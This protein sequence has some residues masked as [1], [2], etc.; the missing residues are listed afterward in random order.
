M[1]REVKKAMVALFVW[2][3]ELNQAIEKA[4]YFEDKSRSIEMFTTVKVCVE[5]LR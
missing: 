1:K 3:V 4:R 5:L 2:N